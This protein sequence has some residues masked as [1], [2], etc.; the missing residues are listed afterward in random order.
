MLSHPYRIY[1]VYNLIYHD[2]KHVFAEIHSVY[3]YYYDPIFHECVHTCFAGLGAF[4][5]I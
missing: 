2:P 3:F 5:I 1:G 4:G